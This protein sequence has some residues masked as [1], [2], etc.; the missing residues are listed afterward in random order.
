MSV[1]NLSASSGAAGASITITGSHF[2]GATG[3]TFAGI[4]ATAFHV[5]LDTQITATVPPGAA[6]GPVAVTGPAGT[7][8]GPS[9]DVLPPVVLNEVA[10]D[11]TGN[12]DVVELRAAVAGSLGGVEL[13]QD[14]TVADPDGT[15]LATLPAI[16]V[17]AGDLV[18]VHLNAPAGVT[19]ETSNMTSCTDPACSAGAWDV[20][21]SGTIPFGDLVLELQVGGEPLDAVPFFA[22]AVTPVPA[23]FTASYQALG[24]ALWVTACS[25]A[26]TNG[27]FD[28]ST[29]GTDTTTGLTAQRDCSGGAGADAN[30][31][32]DWCM[33][34]ATIGS[35][36]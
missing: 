5:D 11:V 14:P 36:N 21:A 3:V 28:W 27:A 15:V 29:M 8:N 6:Q 17:A 4:A 33:Q 31:A 19:D 9:F 10:A 12:D 23:T 25:G 24:S 30:L 20:G 18:V 13:V 26:C 7:V 32:G 1:T 22:P 34:A 16:T 35:P 2:T